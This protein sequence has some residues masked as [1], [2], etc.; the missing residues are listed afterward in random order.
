MHRGDQLVR[1]LKVANLIHH[2]PRRWTRPR[3]AQHFEVDKTTIQRDIQILREMGIEVES[4]GKAGYEIVTDFFLPDLNF[5]LHQALALIT[6]ASF[7]RANEG[8]QVKAA[9]DSAIGK[10][11]AR[12]PPSVQRRL[13][14]LVP[15]IE[16]PA[17][18][19]SPIDDDTQ[20]HREQLYD[21]IRQRRK[22]NLRYNAFSSGRQT[23]HRLAPY[24]IMFRKRA[25][26]VIGHS[27]QS[28]RV[29]TF[30]LNRIQ[31]LF[32]TTEKYTIPDDFS[33]QNYMAK[34]FGVMLGPETHVIV[35]FAPR[36]APLIEEVHWH[37]TQKTRTEP[38][39]KLRFEVTVAG[40]QEI[41]WWV[42]QWGEEAKVIEPQALKKWVAETAAKMVAV[43]QEVHD[44]E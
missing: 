6:A 33:V 35:E 44:E 11:A 1:I 41:G 43:Y 32:P 38:D 37:S 25:W 36:I 27:D 18:Q 22:V 34:S 28:K 14:Q 29:L 15:Q 20:T 26:Y 5:D 12:L 10:I 42:L 17:H 21:A 16:I 7:Y 4:R 40:W 8:E 23:H 13:E 39:G 2:E 19:V 9:L 30:R 31:T 3:L 24:S